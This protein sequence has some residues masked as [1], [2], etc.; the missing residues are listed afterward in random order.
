MGLQY[1]AKILPFTE[2]RRIAAL[3]TKMMGLKPMLGGEVASEPHVTR[4]LSGHS[5]AYIVRGSNDEVVL[6]DA[7]MEEDG[8]NIHATLRQMG[9]SASAV[10]AIF[11]THGH[12]DHAAGA[13]LFADAVVYAHSD[14]HSFLR[15]ETSGE[16]ITGRLAGKLPK[17]QAVH[18]SRLKLISDGESIAVAG[19]TVR[20]HAIPGHT[21]GSMAYQVGDV[22]FMGDAMYFDVHNQVQLPPPIITPKQKFATQSLVASIKKLQAQDIKVVVPSHSGEGTFEALGDFVQR[23]HDS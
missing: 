10:K 4:V 9:L 17:S 2:Q 21:N 6:I 7:G 16:G 12:I 20:A 8:G 14:E 23:T 5:S 1:N 19:L 22:I 11:V 13:Y 3:G 15:G 18:N